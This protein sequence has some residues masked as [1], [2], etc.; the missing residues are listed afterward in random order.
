M[1]SDCG[2]RNKMC[3]RGKFTTRYVHICTAC[4]TTRVLLL[5][6]LFTLV[7]NLPLWRSK[8]RNQLRETSGTPFLNVQ[9]SQRVKVSTAVT[10]SPHSPPY[11]RFVGGSYLPAKISQAV[12]VTGAFV[13]QD[14]CGARGGRKQNGQRRGGNIYVLLAELAAA[15]SADRYI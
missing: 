7:R 9:Q 4:P 8:S 6:S 10:H 1:L 2:A 11:L 14:N 5:C 12:C 15:R 3:R 13:R